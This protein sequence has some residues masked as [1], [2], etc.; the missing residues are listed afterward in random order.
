ML[1]PA[2]IASAITLAF[3]GC[4]TDVAG[5][6][7]ADATSALRCDPFCDP[8]GGTSYEYEGALQGAYDYAFGNFPDGVATGPGPSCVIAGG[9]WDC[10]VEIIT[11]SNPC[12]PVASHCYDNGSL[13]C[14]W[15]AID[16]CH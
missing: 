11:T 13:H 4:A 5:P 8:D 14:D 6:A 16:N 7:T 12:G 15:R 9:G 3:G 2:A 1:L 10:T